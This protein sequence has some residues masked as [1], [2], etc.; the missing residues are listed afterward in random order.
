[1]KRL[2]LLVLLSSCL[3]ACDKA[4]TGE[5]DNAASHTLLVWLG[6]DNNLENEVA[7]KIEA[8]RKGWSGIDGRLTCLI[9]ADTG[10]EGARL[11]RLRATGK[12][13][14]VDTVAVFG[15]ENS[16]SPDIFG[17]RLRYVLTTWPAD[18]YGL[19]FF[20]HAS[21]WLPAGTLQNPT[22]S[23]GWDDGAPGGETGGGRHSEMELADF[24]AAIPDGVLDYMVF[25]ACLM[26][27]VEVAFE[28]RHK[29]DFILASS[30]EMLSPGFTPVYPDALRRLL[31]MSQPVEQRLRGFGQ[32]YM[33]HV[34]SLSGDWRSA[35]LSL[36]ETRE[37]DGLAEW[38]RE[39]LPASFDEPV[40]ED[41]GV[42]HFDRPGA[43]GDFPALPRYFD[44]EE[45]VGLAGLPEAKYIAFQEKLKGIVKWEAHSGNF[46]SSQNGFE[47]KRHCGLTVYRKRASLA[48]LNAAYERTAWWKATRHS[49][50]F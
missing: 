40:E 37:M 34:F 27:G 11:L 18:S 50:I 42:Q 33:D 8:L 25:E 41:Y 10:R 31:A 19:I 21:G 9:Y 48:K 38:I 45:Q 36:I 46:L 29:T 16:T 4:S 26:S 5:P 14:A 44:L 20:S 23:L 3:C 24:A 7:Q 39:E 17:Q 2:L 32:A 13:T 15:P 47:I 22:R 30:A 43:Y 49:D 35:T 28:L 6:G 12:T 1:M